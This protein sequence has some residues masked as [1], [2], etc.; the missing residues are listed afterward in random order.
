MADGTF[1]FRFS[2]DLR[3]DD[4]AGLAAA[5]ARGALV[6]LLVIDAALK[7]RLKASPRRAAFFCGAVRSLDTELRERGRRLIV[8]RGNVAPIL[9]SV[10]RE[11]GASGHRRAIGPDA[12]S[13][14]GIKGTWG[15]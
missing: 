3:L 12:P 2:R 4:H 13:V 8:R 1:I 15:L 6:P 9:T 14:L 10:A 5:A 11:T 7:A